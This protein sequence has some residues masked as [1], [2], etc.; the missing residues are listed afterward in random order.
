MGQK[1]R[2]KKILLNE[3][4]F[5]RVVYN[6]IRIVQLTSTTSLY[7]LVYIGNVPTYLLFM[8]DGLPLFLKL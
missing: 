6:I 4:R 8:E 1:E 7:L 5:G 2:S 3:E